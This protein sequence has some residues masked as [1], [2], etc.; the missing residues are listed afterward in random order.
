VDTHGL[1]SLLRRSAA[2]GVL[3]L[4]VALPAAAGDVKIEYGGEAHAESEM[5]DMVLAA[6]S[7]DVLGSVPAGWSHVVV[8]RSEGN[9]AELA[10]EGN[11]AALGALPAGTYVVVAVPA[12]EHR[13]RA[14][15][16]ELPLRVA[17][18]HA[19]F[20]RVSD[21]DGTGRA[22]M[23]RTTVTAFDQ[24]SRRMAGL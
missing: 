5:Q 22:R 6:V 15:D 23:Q 16:A 8:F 4:V 19:Y 14:G 17:P 21:G 3:A 2:S 7:R 20:L 18:G 11:G 12:G 10:L 9:G 13:F 1:E 24:A